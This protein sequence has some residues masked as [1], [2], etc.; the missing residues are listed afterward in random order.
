[1][2]MSIVSRRAAL[3][4][5]AGRYRNEYYEEANLLLGLG[6]VLLAVLGPGAIVLIAK[7]VQNVLAGGR[8]EG[9]VGARVLRMSTQVCT[10]G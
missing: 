9:D 7:N 2:G 10:R 5:G 8:S 4:P 3:L 6:R 1:M